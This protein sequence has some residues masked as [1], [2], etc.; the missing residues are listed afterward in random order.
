MKYKQARYLSSA[1]FLFMLA[2][3][4]AMPSFLHGQTLKD[5]K[6]SVTF[7]APPSV[8]KASP[9]YLKYNKNFVLVLQADDALADVYDSIYPFFTG[10]NGNP[11]LFFTDGAGNKVPF[12][13]SVNHFSLKSGVYVHNTDTARYLSW[14][15]INDL[16]QHGFSVD[17][18]GFVDPPYGSEQ[19][20][21]VERN[22]SYTIKE[23]A[24]YTQ[25]GITMDTYVL[26][27]NGQDQLVPA[28]DKA[29]YIAF[30]TY[31]SMDLNTNAC[32]RG[33]GFLKM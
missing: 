12:S 25:G 7:A 27:A 2:Y 11:G 33:S 5:V 13:L 15:K 21:Q 22:I 9:A 32:W 19:A 3:M 4:A 28:R 24:P 16:W 29:G 6:I 1:V 20:Y 26:P 30:F 10:T 23:T 8:V 18:R 31:P 17:N 14:K